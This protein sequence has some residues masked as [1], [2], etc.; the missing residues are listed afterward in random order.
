MLTCSIKE[1]DTSSST[2]SKV[3]VFMQN[4]VLYFGILYAA[5]A[6]IAA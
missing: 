1:P 4:V 6:L 5:A 3:S 2:S